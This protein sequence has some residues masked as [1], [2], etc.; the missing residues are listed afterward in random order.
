[1]PQLKQDTA[2]PDVLIRVST[3]ARLHLGFL[4]LNGNTGR[5]FGSIGLAINSHRTTVE[6]SF[7]N[8]LTVTPAN[9]KNKVLTLLEKFYSTLGR[10][11]PKEQQKV[12]LSITELIPE[13]SGFGSGTQFSLAI[14]TALCRLHQIQVS[15]PEIAFHLERGSRSGIGISTFDL[16]GFI[17]DGGRESTT[18]VPP[19]LA[20]YAF[21]SSWRI[22]LIMDTSHQGVDGDNELTAFKTLPIFPLI[23]AQA[24][25]HIT[26]MKLL[27]SLVEKN[28][29]AFG[30]SIT[31]IQSLIGDHFS[32]AQGGRYTSPTVES[33]LHHAQHLGH[34]GISQSSWGPTGCVFVD[35]EESAQQLISELNLYLQNNDN[36]DISLSIAEANSSGADIEMINT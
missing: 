27:P 32:P 30:K 35:S 28:I 29:D 16:G 4:D 31:D 18:T 13:H 34:K 5:K 3:P 26:L 6:V 1:V 8:K 20:H 7:S 14:A 9:K 23:D 2:H 24:I 36:T 12:K 19:L 15:T 11:I 10:H 25:C 33:L 21:P 17:V 22:I